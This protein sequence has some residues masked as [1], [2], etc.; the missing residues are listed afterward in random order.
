[1]KRFNSLETEECPFSNLPEKKA[2]R[3]RGPH[4]DEDGRLQVAKTRTGGAV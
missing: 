2:G 3:W 1:M 4:R